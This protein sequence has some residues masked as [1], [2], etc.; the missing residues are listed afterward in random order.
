MQKLST[1]LFEKGARGLFKNRFR[2]WLGTRGIGGNTIHL[3]L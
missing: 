2:N 1:K 3:Y